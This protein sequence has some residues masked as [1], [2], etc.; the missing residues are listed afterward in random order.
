M[1]VGHMIHMFQNAS[2]Q[3][4]RD[5]VGY[6]V[7]RVPNGHSSRIFLFIIPRRCHFFRSQFLGFDK[8][9]GSAT[10]SDARKEG[11]FAKSNDKSADTEPGATRHVLAGCDFILHGVFPYFVMAGMQIV[12]ALHASMIDGNNLLGLALASH[13]FPG[14]CPMR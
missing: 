11:C 7:S 4:S 2:S 1:E 12:A 10:Q 9:E 13:R 6:R 14:S 3:E 8:G 5:N